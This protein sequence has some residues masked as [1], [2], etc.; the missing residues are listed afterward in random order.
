MVS[1]NKQNIANLPLLNGSLKQS[2]RLNPT[3]SISVRRKVLQPYIV[4]DGQLVQV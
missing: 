1:E 4:Q 2:A 3:D